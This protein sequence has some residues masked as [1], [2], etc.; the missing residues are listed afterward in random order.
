MDIK[1][2]KKTKQK[3]DKRKKPKEIGYSSSIPNWYRLDNAA[4]I[5]PAT[6]RRGWNS[7]YRISAT[8]D[9]DIKPK[10]L[11]K[12]VVDVHP[13]FPSFFVVLRKGFFWYYLEPSDSLDI[14]DEETEYP[15]R[16][17]VIGSGNKPLVRV[18]Y[19]KN[20]ISLEVFHSVADGFGGISLFKTLVYRYLELCGFEMNDPDKE[21]LNYKDDPIESEFEDSFLKYYQK[22][23]RKRPKEQ[24]A[25]QH[26]KRRSHDYKYFRVVTGS[27]LVS[28]IKKVAKEKDVTIT[29]YLTALYI[30]CFANDIKNTAKIKRKLPVR[31]SV[32]IN[33][34]K[35]FPSTTLR[36]FS[37][38]VNVGLDVTKV[39]DITI[40]DILSVIVPQLSEGFEKNNIQNAFCHNVKPEF[41][42]AVK[43]VPLFVKN[44]ILKMVSNSVGESRFTSS[45]SNMGIITLP[46]CMSK[47][48]IDVGT[49]IGPNRNNGINLT[50]SSYGDKM[51]VCF[52]SC[53]ADMAVQKYFFHYLAELGVN[54]EVESNV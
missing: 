27:F 31:I 21:V 45:F 38:F 24:L 9:H 6:M 41:N 28:D 8:L 13:R 5:Y 18:L 22:A 44:F 47:H 54:V 49:V 29:Q 33:L 35:L 12:A 48:V 1:D 39:K 52:S 15:C 36:N 30:L 26:R 43:V 34:R 50:A 7:V 51:S 46:E 37:L 4:K 25:Y 40:D 19:Y 20:R 32:P 16:P 42:L 10:E 2:K 11:R 3:K 53:F 17:F 23:K 14:V